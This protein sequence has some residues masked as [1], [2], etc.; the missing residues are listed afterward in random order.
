MVQNINRS[1]VHSANQHMLVLYDTEGW[2][3]MQM[4]DLMLS[5][6]LIHLSESFM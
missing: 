2:I 3:L 4:L 1:F 5:S 6:L